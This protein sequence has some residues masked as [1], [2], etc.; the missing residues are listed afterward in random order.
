MEKSQNRKVSGLSTMDDHVPIVCWP[1]V[2]L[3]EGQFVWRHYDPKFDKKK[4][5]HIIFLQFNENCRNALNVKL[6]RKIN[7][8]LSNFLF[9]SH[10]F[11]DFVYYFFRSDLSLE[12]LIK[13]R[14]RFFFLL[15]I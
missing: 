14:N 2:S 9:F 8:L 10:R 7:L 13:P 4:I 11:D 6:K 5:S 3:G 12:I 1:P 15:L